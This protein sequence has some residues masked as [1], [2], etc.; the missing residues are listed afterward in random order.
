MDYIDPSSLLRVE[1]EEKEADISNVDYEDDIELIDSDTEP[2]GE[3]IQE[4]VEPNVIVCNENIDEAQSDKSFENKNQDAEDMC[5]LPLSVFNLFDLSNE[6]LQTRN[7]NHTENQTNLV[8]ME[9]ISKKTPEFGSKKLLPVTGKEKTFRNNLFKNSIDAIKLFKLHCT[10]CDKHIGLA[11]STIDNVMRIHKDLNVIMC[12]KCYNFY[13]AGNFPIEEGSE[14]YC[15][16]CGQGGTIFCCSN[17]PKVF[18]E[19]CIILNFGKEK[20]DA[21]EAMETWSCFV[22]M[23]VDLLPH[24]SISWALMR[25]TRERRLKSSTLNENERTLVHTTD[26]STCCSSSSV[27]PTIRL[28]PTNYLQKVPLCLFSKNCL[29]L[30]NNEFSGMTV[31]QAIKQNQIIAIQQPVNHVNISQT[32]PI[33]RRQIST[34]QQLKQPARVKPQIHL[35]NTSKNVHSQS[36]HNNISNSSACEIISLVEDD[37]INLSPSTLYSSA[38]EH[39]DLTWL[40]NAVK[41]SSHCLFNLQTLLNQFDLK[42][43]RLNKDIEEVDCFTN[44]I[45]S[46]IKMTISSLAKIDSNISKDFK[47]YKESKLGNASNIAILKKFTQPRAQVTVINKPQQKAVSFNTTTVPNVSENG[48]EEDLSCLIFCETVMNENIDGNK[49]NVNNNFRSK[50]PVQNMSAKNARKRKSMSTSSSD[51]VIIIDDDEPT[52]KKIN[53]SLR[54]IRGMYKKFNLKPCKVLL[55]RCDQY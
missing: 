22:C 17:C 54:Y 9:N 40:K 55:V 49:E 39:V 2:Y 27:I 19:A 1:I 29:K 38:R 31:R 11:P 34:P 23:P 52:P 26:D 48:E 37:G 16:W 4:Y 47:E 28:P 41:E 50:V 43:P 46:C 53:Y 7:E 42:Y 33:Q 35:N 3:E 45:H 30:V 15:Q 25:L 24:R 5:S 18:C 32:R 14:I 10:V 44:K 21:V 13:G 36:S 6:D 12:F 51:P 8:A 20:R